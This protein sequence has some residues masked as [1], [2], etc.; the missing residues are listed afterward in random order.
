MLANEQNNIPSREERIFSLTST[1]LRIMRVDTVSKLSKLPG[2]NLLIL[3]LISVNTGVRTKKIGKSLNH[4]VAICKS[5]DQENLI[6]KH[7]I[8]HKRLSKEDHPQ[9]KKYHD[10]FI[11]SFLNVHSNYSVVQVK[12]IHKFHVQA[13]PHPLPINLGLFC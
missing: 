2:T 5:D 6:S 12:L 11:P 4:K 7:S 10:I 1:K 8:R 3:F 13:S 9:I